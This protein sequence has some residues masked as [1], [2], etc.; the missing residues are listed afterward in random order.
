LW[1][2]G[3]LLWIVAAL[4]SLKMGSVN[5]ADLDIII[6]LRLPR[7][8]LASAVG[9]GLAVAGCALQA[10]FTNP[11]CEPYTLGISSGA[12]LGA[13]LGG[14][15]GTQWFFWGV[16]G[17]ACLGA[18]IFALILFLISL[19]GAGSFQ[20]LLSGVMLGFLGSSLVALIMALSD[21]SGVQGAILWVLGDLSRARLT[22]STFSFAAILVLSI[23]VFASAP[24]LDALLMGEE[25]AA[26]LGI[27][28]GSTRRKLIVILSLI[29]GICVS[30]AGMIGFVGLIVPHFVRR[31][32]GSLHR[33]LLPLCALWG[34][35]SLTMADAIS[36]LVV[37]PYE[38]PVGVVTAILGAPLFLWIML[39][40]RGVEG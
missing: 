11:L 33:A 1:I 25:G 13:V 27:D 35:G 24:A 3:V 16:A 26:G 9:M 14:F 7:L 5:G 10:L 15:L 29:V 28:V 6:Q 19:R 31:H 21:A 4:I 22:G 12:A 36:R 32:V 18:L 34:A 37:K 17:S 30:T 39:R 40:R 20:L 2:G 8:I 23:Q 38:L